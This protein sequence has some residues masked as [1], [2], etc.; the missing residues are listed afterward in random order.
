[1]GT[2]PVGFV[3]LL[4]R[5]GVLRVAAKVETRLG[6]PVAEPPHIGNGCAMVN[7]A[8]FCWGFVETVTVGATGDTL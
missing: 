8:S 1:V 6:A 4:V 5:P 3:K 2:F 7:V